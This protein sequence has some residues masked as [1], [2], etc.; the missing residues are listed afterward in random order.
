MNGKG[1]KLCIDNM[2]RIVVLWE[3]DSE[4][5]SSVYAFADRL[6]MFNAHLLAR[7]LA[8]TA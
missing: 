8:Q 3:V 6:A 5:I 7:F 1:A 4:G 2:C